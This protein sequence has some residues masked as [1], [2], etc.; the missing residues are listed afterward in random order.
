MSGRDR[1]PETDFVR[2][3]GFTL[4][5]LRGAAESTAAKVRIVRP[6]RRNGRSVYHMASRVTAMHT[7]PKA[8]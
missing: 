4:S 8:K 7:L 3:V 1:A 6:V 5:G 2:P